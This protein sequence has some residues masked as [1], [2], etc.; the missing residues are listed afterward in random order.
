MDSQIPTN[1]EECFDQLEHLLSL[2]DVEAIKNGCFE[3]TEEEIA[4]NVN[5]NMFFGYW[6]HHQLGMY[7][8]NNWGLWTGSDLKDW[9]NSK[10][11]WHADDMSGIIL[12]SFKRRLNK[13]PID[14]EGQ[15]KQYQDYW[16]AAGV[17]PKHN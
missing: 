8:R 15:I 17:D 11:I 1:L 4:E 12:D 5:P 3:P 14:L 10:D 2:K 7:L 6:L 9:F 13:Q 16:K